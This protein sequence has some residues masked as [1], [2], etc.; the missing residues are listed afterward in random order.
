MP[1][2]PESV[3]TFLDTLHRIDLASAVDILLIA[4]LIYALLLWLKG[5]T[6]MSLVKGAGIMIVAG[7]LLG[8]FL[9]LTV[10]NWLLRNSVP[11]LL[12]AVPIV[13]QPEIRRALERVGRARMAARRH[14]RTSERLLVTL[15][16]A[17]AELSSLGLGALIVVERETGL[18]DFIPSGTPIDAAASTALLVNI[19]W[20]N[21]PLHDGAIIVRENRIS[22]AGCTLPLSESSMPGHL[23]T[24]H[25]A[26]LGISERTDAVVIVVSEETGAISLALDGQFIAGLDRERLLEQLR[27]LLGQPEGAALRLM[28]PV[29]P[30]FER[31]RAI[32]RGRDTVR[33]AGRR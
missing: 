29:R 5:T 6:G 32:D 26:A 7:L 20:R 9:N 4:L 31:G 13:F 24:R 14:R 19:F 10:V 3:R 12:V 1:Q 11:A 18:D 23:G 21:T 17:A 16:Q 30:R 15:A 22:A 27:V 8:S 2:P 25:R 28:Q 33:R